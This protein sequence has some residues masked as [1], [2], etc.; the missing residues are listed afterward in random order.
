MREFARTNTKDG[1]NK[2]ISADHFIIISSVILVLSPINSDQA[3]STGTAIKNIS[4]L[5][6]FPD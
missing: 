5:H 2:N 1:A 6:Y 3:G 4:S